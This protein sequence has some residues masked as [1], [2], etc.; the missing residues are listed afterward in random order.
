MV[1]ALRNVARHFDVLDLIA[2]HRHLVGIEGQDVG[3]HQH[4]IHVQASSNAGIGVLARLAVLVHRGLVGMRAV[5]QTLGGDTGEEPGQLGNLGDIGLAIKSDLLRIEAC[6]QPGGG[7]LQARTLD[8]GR[9]VALDERVVIGHEVERIDV[10]APAGG[11]GRANGADVVT[12]VRRAGGGDAGKYA[13]L[14]ER[15]FNS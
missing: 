15:F 1:E 6:G 7:D 5:E 9:V 10:I 12:K 3:G 14:H 13:G 4:R 8:A 11:H 2:S